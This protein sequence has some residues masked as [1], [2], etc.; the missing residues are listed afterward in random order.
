MSPFEAFAEF[1]EA[2]SVE[3]FILLLRH[4][5]KLLSS[6]I[7]GGTLFE[8]VFSFLLISLSLFF[9]GFKSCLSSLLSC[10]LESSLLSCLEG[11]LTLLPLPFALF[12]RLLQLSLLLLSASSQLFLSTLLSKSCLTLLILLALSFLSF[13]SLF[14]LLLL[15]QQFSLLRM[16]IDLLNHQIILAHFSQ[17]VT[18]AQATAKRVGGLSDI[19]ACRWMRNSQRAVNSIAVSHFNLVIRWR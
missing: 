3:S 11:S 18:T 4:L 13:P 9:E 5:A 2:L 16:D 14:S 15:P 7:L 19:L 12:K 8:L 17:T 1:L 6:Q 10:S